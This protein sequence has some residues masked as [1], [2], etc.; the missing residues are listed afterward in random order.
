MLRASLLWLSERQSLAQFI[1]RNR[2][3]KLASH[4]GHETPEE[5][6]APCAS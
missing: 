1:R 2:R 5:G 3:A 4:R 6:V